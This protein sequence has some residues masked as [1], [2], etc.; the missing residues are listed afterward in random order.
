[1]NIRRIMPVV[2][3]AD[4]SAARGFYVD[5]LGLR[6]AMEEDGM[7]MLASRSTPTTQ[8]IVAWDSPTAVDP[9]LRGVDVS[10]EVDDADAAFRAA[11]AAGLRIVR[12]PRD[13]PWGIRRFFVAD[14]TGRV[15]NVA[16]HIAEH[17]TA[18]P[19]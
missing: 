5:L 14:G 16:S 19:D 10:I 2:R 8:I 11:T 9:E 17:P 4:P 7:M 12:P 6:P 13:E 3:A 15:V 18:S 1:M